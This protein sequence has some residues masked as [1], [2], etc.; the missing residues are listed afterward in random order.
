MSEFPSLPLPVIE[1]R[2]AWILTHSGF[3]KWLKDALRNALDRDPVDVA[4]DLALLGQLLQPWAHTRIDQ[5]LGLS[6]RDLAEALKQS[7]SIDA[8]GSGGSDG[9]R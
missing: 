8:I 1:Q 7:G 5:L 3:S 2:I 9:G 4:N 6:D